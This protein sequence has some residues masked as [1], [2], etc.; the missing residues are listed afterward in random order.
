MS[1]PVRRPAVFL[2]RD[3][4]LNVPVVRDGLPHPPATLAELKLYDS[5]PEACRMLHAAGWVLVVVTNQPDVGRGTQTRETV[6]AMHARLRE[7]LP[8]IARVE[9]CF[10]PGRGTADP[11]D[12]RRKPA[13][14]MLLDAAEVLGLHLSRSWMVGDR[15]RDVECGRRAGVRTIFIDHG[16]REELR[17]RPTHTV[18][19]LAEAVPIILAAGGT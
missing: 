8:E 7:L 2:D 9:T 5:V 1:P 4:T 12:R 16:Y 18:R 14:G 17:S 19:S 10:A 15:W 6:E 13:P 11:Q 3:G